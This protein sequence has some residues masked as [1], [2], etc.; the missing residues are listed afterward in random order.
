MSEKLP[1]DRMITVKWLFFCYSK[2]MFFV[3]GQLWNLG[4]FL[5]RINF[6]LKMQLR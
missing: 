5:L 4:K 6:L 1:F 2:N 3:G